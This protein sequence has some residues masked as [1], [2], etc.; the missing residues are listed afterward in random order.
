MKKIIGIFLLTIGSIQA[1]EVNTTPTKTIIK[2]GS[3]YAY[4]GWNR[5]LYSKSDIHFKGNNYDF[6]LTN[7]EARDRQSKFAFSTYFQTVTI[8][9]YNLRI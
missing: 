4:W 2:K 5:S 7:I 1:Q 9:Q 3:F 8:P 6:T